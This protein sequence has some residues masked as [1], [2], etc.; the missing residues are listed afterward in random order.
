[1]RASE[2]EREGRGEGGR[3]K[4]GGIFLGFGQQVSYFYWIIQCPLNYSHSG[5]EG[6]LVHWSTLSTPLSMGV[7][8][9]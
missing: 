7:C 2:W 1:M 4:E 8:M 5:S 3:E 9:D 6:A